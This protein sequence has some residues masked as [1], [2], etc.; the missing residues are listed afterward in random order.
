MYSKDLWPLV[1]QDSL[2]CEW[3]LS[4]M[5]SDRVPGHCLPSVSPGIPAHPETE[6]GGLLALVLALAVA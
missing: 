1:L 3:T 4:S 5:V 2:A 6:V